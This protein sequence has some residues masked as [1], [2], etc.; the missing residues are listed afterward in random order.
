MTDFTIKCAECGFFLSYTLKD[1]S[2][3]DISEFVLFGKVYLCKQ[4]YA[5][6]GKHK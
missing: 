6:R 1:E 2:E 5:K 3:L 4:C